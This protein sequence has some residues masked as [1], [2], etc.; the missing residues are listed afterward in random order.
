MNLENTLTRSLSLELALDNRIQ[1]SLGKISN[2][3]Q[4]A[5]IVTQKQTNTL[6]PILKLLDSGVKEITNNADAV[7]KE[8]YAHQ[9]CYAIAESLC[10]FFANGGHAESEIVI[11]I[12]D[13]GE[14]AHWLTR[15]EYN[16][17][18]YFA[19]AYGIYSDLEKI[20]AR[21]QNTTIIDIEF[22]EPGDS[23]SPFYETYTDMRMEVLSAVECY[24]DENFEDIDMDEK[25]D[26]IDLFFDKEVLHAMDVTL[27]RELTSVL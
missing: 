15:F 10:E 2:P 20:E 3:S 4:A 16:G 22:Y 11:L 14:P 25:Y 5:K 1:H 8:L 26:L 24:I 23:D 19:D 7:F 27:N 6:K 17:T 12:A 18:M 9:H 13:D 21:Y